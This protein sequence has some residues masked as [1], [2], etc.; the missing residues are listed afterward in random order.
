ML[1]KA[2]LSRIDLASVRAFAIAAHANVVNE[3]GSLGQARKYTGE[4]YISHP[5]AVA[6]LVASVP[7]A[8][9]EMVAAA[10]L[11]DVVED[12]NTTL[13]DVESLC[14]A[15]VATYVDWLTTQTTEADGN[16]ARRKQIDRERMAR[17]PGEVHTI[18]AAD[19]IH[20]SIS[21]SV[22]KPDYA[23]KTYLPEKL[24]MLDVLTRAD[25]GLMLWAR[26]I[27]EQALQVPRN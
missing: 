20:N 9:A 16:R 2:S 26:Q 11:H 10:L 6:G 8:T 25:R 12:T 21:I 23:V 4:P 3:D 13:A 15:N 27:C 17:A 19:I 1:S 5:L 22:F 24:A 14:G 7:G 18:K